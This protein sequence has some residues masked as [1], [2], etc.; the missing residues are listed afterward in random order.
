LGHGDG[1][2]LGNRFRLVVG[3]GESGEFWRRQ[4]LGSG[5]GSDGLIGIT[6]LQKSL[7]RN[8]R[9]LLNGKS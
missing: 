1:F 9:L 2:G 7:L 4:V 3:V 8:S 5:G 6:V